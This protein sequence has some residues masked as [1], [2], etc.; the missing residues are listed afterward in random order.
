MAFVDADV[1]VDPDWLDRLLEAS[2]GGQFV[3]AGAVRNGTPSSDW[4]TVEYLVQFLDL[5]PSRPAASA[6]HGATCN[7]LVPRWLWEVY[8]PWPEGMG[9]GEDTVLTL[10]AATDGR[11]RF[12]PAAVVSHLNR[13]TRADVLAHQRDFGVFTARLSLTCPQLPHGWLQRRALLAPIAVIGR[14]ASVMRRAVAWK[15]VQMGRLAAL[16]PRVALALA[17][18]GAGLATELVR[19]HRARRGGHPT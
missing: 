15:P 16:M 17:F 9:G 12:A 18:W 2:D 8:G 14:I 6:R 19:L 13:T 11:L 5:A 3:V 10:A 1:I 4:G 7:L